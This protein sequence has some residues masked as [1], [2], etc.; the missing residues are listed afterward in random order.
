MDQSRDALD[1]EKTVYQEISGGRDEIELGKAE[2]NARA[3]CS[4]LNF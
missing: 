2:V 1:A 3:Y 4:W